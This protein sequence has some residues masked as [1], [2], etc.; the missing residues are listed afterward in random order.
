MTAAVFYVHRLRYLHVPKSFL[1][2]LIKCLK[3]FVNTDTGEL[4]I[5]KC[6]GQASNLFQLSIV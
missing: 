1:F 3:P 6:H 4:I 5:L 2:V